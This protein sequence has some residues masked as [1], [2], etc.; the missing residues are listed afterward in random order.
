MDSTLTKA[1]AVLIAL[2]AFV[3]LLNWCYL[4]ASYRYKRFYSSVPL[5]GAILLGAGMFM[6]PSSR[7]YCWGAV[8]L[9][10]GTLVFLAAS[11]ALLREAWST[12]SF[13]LVCEYLGQAAGKTAHLR[14][15]RRGIFT[16][17]LELRRLPGESGL[18]GS[19]QIGT[20]RREGSQL[21][22]Q[23]KGES[24]VFEVV[25]DTPTEILRQS[26]GFPSWEGSEDLSLSKINFAVIPKNGTV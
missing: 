17:R 12:S 1:A 3:A 11:P 26:V 2:G 23:I 25:A 19:G 15:F 14:L 21:T 4:Y 20:W 24:A 6:L 13:N 7:R 5:V 10:Y 18:A 9:D 16:M 8:I 22:L